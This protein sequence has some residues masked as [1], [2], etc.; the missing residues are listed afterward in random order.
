MQGIP[1]DPRSDEDTDDQRGDD[2]S[3][4]Q[5]GAESRRAGSHRVLVG[6]VVEVP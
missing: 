5:A 1:G 3:E 2:G 4:E 6:I